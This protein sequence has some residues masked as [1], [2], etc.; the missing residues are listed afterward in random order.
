MLSALAPLGE[1]DLVRILTE[2][3]NALVRQ[4][5]KFFE[6]E[7]ADLSFTDDALVAIAKIARENDTGA[8]G[9]RSVVEGG[10]FDLM[11]DL[12]ESGKGSKYVVT[13]E[14]VRGESEVLKKAA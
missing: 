3:K 4:Y 14:M 11:Y 1:Q 7:G 10:M 9:L 12:P 5:R 13:P 8:R 2:P 6:M